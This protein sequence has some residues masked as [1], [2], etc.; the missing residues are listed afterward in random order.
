MRRTGAGCGRKAADEGEAV[1]KGRAVAAAR[2]SRGIGVMLQRGQ[3][4]LCGGLCRFLNESQ[5]R[6]IILWR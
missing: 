2:G 1:R 5:A 4:L 3:E 6:G